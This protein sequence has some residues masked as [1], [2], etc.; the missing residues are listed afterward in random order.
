MAIFA[1]TLEA[2]MRIPAAKSQFFADSSKILRLA[3]NLITFR[4]LFTK[5]FVG[6]RRVRSLLAPDKWGDPEIRDKFALT[7]LLK[8]QS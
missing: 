7:V 2:Y 3:K 4:S 5:F 8:A 6:E 1:T